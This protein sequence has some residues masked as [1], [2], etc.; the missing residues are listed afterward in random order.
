MN[1]G[2]SMML[3]LSTTA[4]IL[5]MGLLDTNHRIWRRWKKSDQEERNE[6]E[7]SF[8]LVFA[9]TTIL[10][11]IRLFIVPLYFF[12]LQSFIPAIPGAMCLWGVFNALPQFLW[13]ALI[14]NLALPLLYAG[15]LVMAHIN[16]QCKRNPLV[17]NMSGLFI[18]LSP[19]LLI[20]SI[21]DLTIF[22]KITPVQVTCCTNAIDVGPAAQALHA[23]PPS[24][25]AL[26]GQQI[27]LLLF[28]LVSSLFAV[29]AFLSTK[30]S[31]FE[32]P[33]RLLTI[34]LVPTT[35]ITMAEVFTPW[36]LNLPFHYCPFC[37]VARSPPSLL[38]VLLY[39]LAIAAPWWT[40]ITQRLG[41][42][43]DESKNTEKTT[44]TKLWKTAA[45]ASLL[46]LIIIIVATIT[47]FS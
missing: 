16:A 25:G 30:K 42:E 31:V 46:G 41:R 27:M 12:T 17:G 10:L 40:M 9:A 34:I 4:L 35:V 38:F 8:Y 1:F 11:A 29:F 5:A 13:P 15:W 32:W 3:L 26:S 28:I 39:W 6:L 7:K 44:R 18:L 37:L 14:L 43:D 22:I 33:A 36:I 47:S 2:T 19:L 23:F 45:T 20:D 24:I 21:L